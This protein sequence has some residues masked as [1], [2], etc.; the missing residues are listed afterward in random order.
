MA[1]AHLQLV[2]FCFDKVLTKTKMRSFFRDLSRSRYGVVAMACLVES[3]KYHRSVPVPMTWSDL[4][5]QNSR[6]PVFFPADL[7]S[8]ARAV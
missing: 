4:E 1:A 7:H 2:L 6:Y 8:N 5:R 3:D